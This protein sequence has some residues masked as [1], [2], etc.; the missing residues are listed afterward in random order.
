MEGVIAK[1]SAE[2]VV[3]DLQGRFLVANVFVNGKQIDFVTETK[4]DIGPFLTEE[5]NKIVIKVKSSLRNLMG[6]H[7]F[8]PCAELTSVA[9]Y[10]FTLRGSWKDGIS[11]RY[12][13]VYN[14][15]PFGVNRILLKE[16]K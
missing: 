8:E 1:S 9:P 2:E 5:Q 4:K 7:H 15:V 11:P 14:C 13:K 16:G 3:L 10:H 6:P 12:T